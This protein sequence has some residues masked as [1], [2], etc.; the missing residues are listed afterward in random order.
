MFSKS[1][2]LLLAVTLMAAPL[3][4]ALAQG[5]S[6]NSASSASGTMSSPS[7]TTTTQP[8]GSSA[9][10]NPNVPGATGNTVV[11]GSSSSMAGSNRVDP[12]PASNT[13]NPTGGGK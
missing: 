8:Y 1:R 12:N 5:T 4:V 2:S 7:T 13:T 9:A 6:P 3:S 11:K 10:T